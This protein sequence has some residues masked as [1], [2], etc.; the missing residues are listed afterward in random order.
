MAGALF[1]KKIRSVCD[2][3][4]PDPPEGTGPHGKGVNRAVRGHGGMVFRRLNRLGRASML[5]GKGPCV[6]VNMIA[7]I[8]RYYLYPEIEAGANVGRQ[9]KHAWSQLSSRMPPMSFSFFR[10]WVASRQPM[11][12]QSGGAP[13][14]F[15]HLDQVRFIGE[16]QN[17]AGVPAGE[18]SSTAGRADGDRRRVGRHQDECSEGSNGLDNWR[19][20]GWRYYPK[21]TSRIIITEKPAMV[22]MVTRSMWAGTRWDS[23]ISSS[24]TTKIMAPAAKQRA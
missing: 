21:A 3:H 13:M 19:I 11:P 23:G 4:R 2:F 12:P 8:N 6:P 18:R 14:Q 9:K 16:Q 22:A 20:A 24:T 10:K 7:F 15:P 17:R 5:S 1:D